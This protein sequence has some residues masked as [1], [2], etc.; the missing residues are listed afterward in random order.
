MRRA[1]FVITVALAALATAAW[2][3]A[4]APRSAGSQD[5]PSRTQ[6]VQRPD[7]FNGDGFS[8]LAVGVPAE[9][10]G[11]AFAAGTVNVLLGSGAGLEATDQTL[12]QANPESVDQFGGALAKGDFNGDGFDDLAVGAPRED[13]AAASFAGA[14][15]V[16]YGSATGLPSGSQVLIQGNPEGDDRFG[17]A[18]DAGFFNDDDFMDLAVGAPGET[19]GGDVAAGA[20]NVFYGSAAGLPAASQAL[21]Q[22]NPEPGDRFGSALAAGFFDDGNPSDLAAGAPGEAVGTLDGA[23]AVNVFFGEAGGLPAAS[24]ALLQGNPEPGDGFGASLAAGFFD[25]GI[26]MDLAA[27]APTETVG[28]RSAAGAVNVFFGGA[29]TGLSTSSAAYTQGPGTGGVAEAGDLFGA[30]LA[31][32]FFDGVA[33]WDLAVGSPLED[34]GDREDA[35]AVNVLYGTPAGLAGR[36][37]VLVQGSPGVGGTAEAGDLFGLALARGVFENN[38]NGDG[39]D[40]LAVGAPNEDLG[41]KTDAGAVNVLY[42]AAGGLGSA[43]GQLFSQDSPGMGGTAEPFDGFGA[44]LD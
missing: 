24:E 6:G 27:G 32:G 16:F 36:D 5:R 14:V 17:S 7:D 39:F 1:V 41:A 8:D 15:N 35:G 21:L 43:D 29:P 2:P 18:L 44:E 37:Q 40:D 30:S 31:A 13:L 34:L 20:V 33:N 11:T 38:F 22:G 42:G 4:G 10:V 26:F 3:A 19:V 12:L 9:A 28:T 23:G 25:D